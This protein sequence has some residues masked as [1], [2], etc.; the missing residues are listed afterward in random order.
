[1][2]LRLDDDD[3]DDDDVI[4]APCEA[5]PLT[6]YMHIDDT[7]CHMMMMMMMIYGNYKLSDPRL[8]GVV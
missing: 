3:D 4:K 6:I 7:R 8:A 2:L 5:A 1:M